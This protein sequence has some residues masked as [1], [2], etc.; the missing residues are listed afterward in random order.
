MIKLIF[1]LSQIPSNIISSVSL[2]SNS[3]LFCK[4]YSSVERDCCEFRMSKMN[5]KK[6]VWNAL[7][8][9]FFFHS[10]LYLQIIEKVR[11][12]GHFWCC[13]SQKFFFIFFLFYY[14]FSTEQD[15]NKS[16][17]I[18]SFW[19]SLLLCSLP[20]LWDDLF[21]QFRRIN[22]TFFSCK[23]YGIAQWKFLILPRN[24]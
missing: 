12:C 6:T 7:K 23:M 2:K 9:L 13:N 15:A 4:N 17:T 3:K 1:L 24:F 16:V 8:F 19:A 21:R 10:F 18:K 22:Y 5:E 11:N 14:L 20:S